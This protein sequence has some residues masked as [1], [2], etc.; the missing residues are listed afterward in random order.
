[1]RACPS[2]VDFDEPV[3]S[4]FSYCKSQQRAARNSL[5]SWW[6]LVWPRSAAIVVHNLW[7]VNRISRPC[8]Y[9]DLIVTLVVTRWGLMSFWACEEALSLTLSRGIIATGLS[10]TKVSSNRLN[11]RRRLGSR[12]SIFH[13]I[14]MQSFGLVL[15]ITVLKAQRSQPKS[16]VSLVVTTFSHV[17]AA[18]VAK[19]QVLLLMSRTT[20]KGRRFFDWWRAISPVQS[21]QGQ[22]YV[23]FYRMFLLLPK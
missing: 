9:F 3:S 23:L 18:L 16:V 6:G 17:P 13:T 7:F 10:L 11:M 12:I 15:T 4:A 22:Q 2:D 5:S 1:M 21:D 19:K 14:P 8:R 20:F